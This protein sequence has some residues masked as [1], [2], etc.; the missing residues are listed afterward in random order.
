MGSHTLEL[1][2]PATNADIAIQAITHGA[3]AI[4]MGATSHGARK[5]AANSI[6][7][8]AKVVDFAHQY[9]AKVYVT[10]NTIVYEHEL[11]QVEKL[12]LDLYKTGVDALIVQDMA[13]LRMDLPPIPLHASTQ[14]DIRTPEKALFLQE[15]GFS[16]IVLA[17]ELTLPEIKA[18]VDTVNIPVEC[19]IHGALCVGYSGRCHASFA[20]L[21]RS[22]NRGECAQIC[23]LPYT[24][25]D[26][27]G[28]IIAKDKYLLSLRDFN[29]S[30]HL[31]ELVD[32]GVRSFKIEGRLKEMDYVKNITAFYNLK[33]N[34]IIS[35]NPE[36]LRRSSFGKS[37]PMFTPCP[38]KSFNRGFT[39]YFLSD[40]RPANIASM[41]SPKSMGEII[42]D[43]SDLHN[44]DGIS[45]FDRNGQYQGVN[46][47]RIEKGK[48]ITGRKVDIPNGAQ[49]HRTF[50]LHW[51]KMIQ[52][53]SAVRKIGLDI[54]ID[55]GGVTAKDQRGVMVRIP[56]D[57][58]TEIAKNKM[59]YQNEFSKLGNTIYTL[60]S[61]KSTLSPEVFIPKSTIGILRRKIVEALGISNKITYPIELR[62]KE[63]IAFP[64]PE[65][66]VDFKDNIANSLATQVYRD[67]G[68]VDIN[69]ALECGKKSAPCGTTLMTTRH[70]I[71]RELGMCKK[72]YPKKF[73]EPLTI[74][75]SSTSFT[76]KFDCKNCEMQLLSPARKNIPNGT[77]HKF[78]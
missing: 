34:E 75:N 36:S 50:D 21:G 19:F 48:I 1:L 73:Q 8:I 70:C 42:N 62:R 68:V 14:C 58:H 28:K 64:F 27:S 57:I 2:S 45:Y 35:M 22:A 78:R 6:E 20:T 65:S 76:L 5:S 30:N 46:V 47:N 12:C 24:L 26:H 37:V 40:R 13:L 32:A 56:L 61:Y 18:I 31:Q 38:E 11:R 17:R 9:R 74:S 4:Y 25:K 49:I 71:L 54:E 15:A 29:A 10:V 63:N 44:G 60:S 67:H 23:R 52:K 41:L 43:V 39:E 69:Q 16:Q 53:E 33:L 59:D 3:D 55:N 51:Q 66:A 72:E 77:P 7:D